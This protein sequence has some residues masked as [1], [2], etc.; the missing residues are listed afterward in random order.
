MKK[1]LLLSFLSLFLVFKGWS[2][3]QNSTV[4]KKTTASGI[5]FII[6]EYNELNSD[7]VKKSIAFFKKSYRDLVE[8]NI[9]KKGHKNLI[10]FK[11]VGSTFTITIVASCMTV[12][13]YNVSCAN[14]MLDCIEN[15]LLMSNLIE[16]SCYYQQML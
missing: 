11:K 8:E 10:N 3:E 15:I 7:K 4:L 9:A 6:Q 14:S 1:I 13:L 5:N 2:S 16:L 12:T